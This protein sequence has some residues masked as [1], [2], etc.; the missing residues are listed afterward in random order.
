M[1]EERERRWRRANPILAEDWDRMM[2]EKRE[3]LECFSRLWSLT[4]RQEA[5]VITNRLHQITNQLNVQ[6]WLILLAARRR[7]EERNP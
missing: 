4:D 1:H 2:R 6:G 5:V 7:W 3:A